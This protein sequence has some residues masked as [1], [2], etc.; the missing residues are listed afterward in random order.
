MKNANLRNG[1]YVCESRLLGPLGLLYV[2]EVLVGM[3]TDPKGVRP[4]ESEV[5]LQVGAPPL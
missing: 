4:L 5:P 2:A 1:V 3:A